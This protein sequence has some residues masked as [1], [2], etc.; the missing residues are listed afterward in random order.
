[1][2]RLRIEKEVALAILGIVLAIVGILA[3]ILG[4]K[5]DEWPE[6]IELWTHLLQVFVAE[7]IANKW[8]L[9][10]F[11]L[12]TFAL[13]FSVRR[14]RSPNVLSA[15]EF[16]ERYQNLFAKN[17]IRTL[18]V[19]GYTYETVRDYQKYEHLYE[20]GLEIRVLNRCWIAE[21]ADEETHN[22]KI[23]GLNIRRWKKSETI[24]QMAQTPW[25]YKARRQ[26][27]YYNFS[28]PLIK[29][30]ILRSKHTSWAFVNFYKWEEVPSNGGSQFKGADMGMIF[31]DG[32]QPEEQ[33]KID[34][35]ASQFELIWKYRSFAAD[36][37]RPDYRPYMPVDEIQLPLQYDSQKTSTR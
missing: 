36:Q 19:F 33:S 15:A 30:V 9:L 14:K 6:K 20:D 18:L 23:E 27:R 13:G 12:A 24:R 28:H 25:T 1:M 22:K 2:N 21:R 26:V 37:T 29:G 4:L 32:S 35:L 34:A 10:I 5:P 17:D 7:S 31:L 8:K 16:T 11:A 3:T